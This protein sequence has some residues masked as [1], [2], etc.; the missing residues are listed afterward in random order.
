[1]KK[2]S[3]SDVVHLENQITLSILFIIYDVDLNGAALN[4]K[5]LLLLL[6]SKKM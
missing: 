3:Q 4:H 2:D 5:L 6:L 1:M